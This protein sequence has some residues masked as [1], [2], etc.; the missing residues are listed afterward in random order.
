MLQAKA[1]SLQVRNGA[2]IIIC[3]DLE[4]WMLKENVGYEEE[5]H[6]KDFEGYSYIACKNAIIVTQ[7]VLH[8]VTLTVNSK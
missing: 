7:E 6:C 3:K 8:V 2:R 5:H 1:P 4:G